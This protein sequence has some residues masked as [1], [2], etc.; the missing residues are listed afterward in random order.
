[1]EESR[2]DLTIS[3]ISANNLP[4]LLPCLES[5]FAA[6]HALSLEVFLVDNDSSD[7]TADEV[8]ARY[9]QVK[10]IRNTVR[11]GFSTN[12]NM[13]L[14]QGAGRH[15][16]L[17]NDDTVILGDALAILVRFLDD[18]PRAGAAGAALQNADGS[19]QA[20]FARFPR[21]ILEGIRPAT[22]WVR[23]PGQMTPME[24]DSVCGAALV[25]RREILDDVGGLDSAFD[26]IY[27]EEVDWCYR[28]S[29]AGWKIYSL[30]AAQVIHHGSQTMNRAVPRKYE[31]LL[32]HKLLYFRKHN[33]WLGA[34]AYR[35]SLGAATL[36]KVAWWSLAS[37]GGPN[38]AHAREKT[39]LHLQLLKGIRG[40]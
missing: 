1:M 7:R 31:L 2:P 13:V 34:T 19:F 35:L 33:G 22:S 36:G 16:M 32:S 27:S 23:A 39:Q 18:H 8:Q 20:A 15:L 26:P 10:I 40:L 30:P 4:L 14:A 29:Q 38:A 3:V 12:N 25:V 17:L 21:P 37:I 11:Q 24:V 5:V 9:P 28:I 6:P